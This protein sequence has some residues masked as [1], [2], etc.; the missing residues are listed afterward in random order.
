MNNY[1]KCESIYKSRADIVT[2]IKIIGLDVSKN[3][4][5]QKSFIN[6][7]SN[8]YITPVMGN[9]LKLANKYILKNL[10]NYVDEGQNDE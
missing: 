2:A 9:P 1:E 6:R 5:K 4:L 10:Q 7:I 3:I 8:P